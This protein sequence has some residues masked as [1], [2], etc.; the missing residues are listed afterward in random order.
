MDLMLVVAL[1]L[2]SGRFLTRERSESFLSA[3]GP[4]LANHAVLDLTP[5]MAFRSQ[6]IVRWWR[7]RYL[8]EPIPA[9]QEVER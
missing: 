2:D 9:P 7:Q 8:P 5:E 3:A 1:S 4:L 6:R